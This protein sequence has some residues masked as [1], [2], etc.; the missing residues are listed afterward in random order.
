MAIAAFTPTKNYADGAKWTKA[1]M[2]AFVDGLDTWIA[3]EV[4]AKAPDKT[5]TETISGTWTFSAA[6]TFAGIKFSTNTITRSDND[7]WTLPDLGNQNFVG[8]TGT[9]TLTNKTLDAP[10]FTG[11]VTVPAVDPPGAANALTKE[12]I[13]K[14]WAYITISGG[15]PTLTN[16]YNVSGLVDGGAGI[17]TVTWDRDFANANY[18]V[19][20]TAEDPNGTDPFICSW[21]NKLVGSVDIYTRLKSTGALTD[22]INITVIACGDQ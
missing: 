16:A 14:G 13:V 10:T 17:T 5:G 9:Q 1:V 4:E 12:S 11:I 6:P 2:D 3:S 15:V 22:N 19:V 21:R 18:A 8:D 20:A 7:V